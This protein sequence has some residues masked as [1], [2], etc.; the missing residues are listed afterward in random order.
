MGK[1]FED[2]GAARRTLARHW[3]QEI[4]D[5]IIDPYTGAGRV[6][7]VA[8]FA[9]DQPPALNSLVADLDF[10]DELPERRDEIRRA[11]LDDAQTILNTW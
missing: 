2:D 1:P 9:L 8:W 11:L 10:W 6:I 5:G 7:G 4:V 3:L